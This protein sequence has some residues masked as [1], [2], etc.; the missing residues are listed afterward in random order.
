[1][2]QARQILFKKS[3][4]LNFRLKVQSHLDLISEATERNFIN[5]TL[6]ISLELSTFPFSQLP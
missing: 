3:P 4:I 5:R 1:M 2:L 6:L